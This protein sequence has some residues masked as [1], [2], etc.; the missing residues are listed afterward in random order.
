MY[1]SSDIDENSIHYFFASQY[2]NTLHVELDDIPARYYQLSILN[3]NGQV[4]FNQKAESG[5]RIEINT[6]QINS[7]LYI[8]VAQYNR[9]VITRKIILH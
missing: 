2:E 6:D 5:N 7:G 1:K 4:I 8:M 9:Q 3:T